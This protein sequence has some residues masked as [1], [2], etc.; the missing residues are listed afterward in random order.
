[1]GDG[2]NPKTS[3]HLIKCY[4]L[5]RLLYGLE[6]IHLATTDLQ[7]RDN[8]ITPTFNTPTVITP[9][10]NTPTVITPTLN[11]PTLITPTIITPT[12]NTWTVTDSLCN[13]GAF[14]NANAVRDCPFK[15]KGA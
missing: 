3:V 13:S 7:Q 6:V 10:L 2:R 4:V 11:Y 12:L 9:T 14:N 1:M 15:L 8:V 5:P